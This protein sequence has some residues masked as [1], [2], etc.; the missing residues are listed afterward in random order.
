M[1]RVIDENGSVQE[2]VI[3]AV[4]PPVTAI[5]SGTLTT[6]Q[7]LTTADTT[8]FGQLTIADAEAG[9]QYLVTCSGELTIN[10]LDVTDEVDI[11]LVQSQNDAGFVAIDSAFLAY[12]PATPVPYI[13]SLCCQ[14]LLTIGVSGTLVIRAQGIV[15]A[16]ATASIGAGVLS[17]VRL[18]IL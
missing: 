11:Q 10:A 2:I 5:N 16:T 4:T 3:E 1:T 9:Q 15:S 8:T 17:A 14:G 7:A 12:G 18:D 6:G 13:D